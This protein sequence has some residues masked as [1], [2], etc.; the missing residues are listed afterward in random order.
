MIMCIVT[1]GAISQIGKG[2]YA[3]KQL[4]LF[5]NNHVTLLD[6]DNGRISKLQGIII[7]HMYDAYI[8][9]NAKINRFNIEEIFEFTSCGT[10]K[11]R[12]FRN[13]IASLVKKSMVVYIDDEYI[14]LTAKGIGMGRYLSPV[15]PLQYFSS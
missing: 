5:T 11:M 6:E 1:T 4:A 8:A 15:E 12:E 3:M 14:K 2:R 13:G 7:S 9:S 10:R